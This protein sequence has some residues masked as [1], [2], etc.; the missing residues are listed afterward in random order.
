M[1]YLEDE[2]KEERRR[3]SNSRHLNPPIV[4]F[5][6]RFP[7][8]STLGVVLINLIEPALRVEHPDGR[9]C[10][11]KRKRVVSRRDK[12]RL[13]N[14]RR[15]R[16]RKETKDELLTTCTSQSHSRITNELSAPAHRAEEAKSE[17]MSVFRF[18]SN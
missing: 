18:L 12:F 13:A 11:Q 17:Q 1:S 16:A 2:R 9:G 5:D 3:D 6:T 15:G 10:A 14:A 7:I 4:L 8:R